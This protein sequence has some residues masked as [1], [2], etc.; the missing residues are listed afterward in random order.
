M[1]GYRW[2]EQRRTGNRGGIAILVKDGIAV[3]RVVGNEYAQFVELRPPQGDMLTVA[4]VYLPP[5]TNLGRRNLTEAVVRE[6]CI[7][8][9]SRVHLESQLLLAGD[10]NARTGTLVPRLEG[11]THPPRVACDAVVCP[12]GSWL[13]DHGRLFSLRM[14]NG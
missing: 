3:H 13:I 8:V 1:P 5:T 11:T 10:F 7:D 12:R 6:Q 9:L 4:N 2:Y 14:L